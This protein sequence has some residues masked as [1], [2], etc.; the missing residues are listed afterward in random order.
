MMGGVAAILLIVLLYLL[1]IIVHCVW[2]NRMNKNARAL[3]A[4]DMEHTPAW[5]VGYYFIPSPVERP[6]G[7]LARV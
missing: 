1:T 4:R 5:A 2:T 7:E 3:G 6:V